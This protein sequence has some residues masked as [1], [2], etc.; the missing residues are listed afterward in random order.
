MTGTSPQRSAAPPFSDRGSWG[1]VVA[2]A[3]LPPG[4]EA[5][6]STLVTTSVDPARSMAP[7]TAPATRCM[8]RPL[9]RAGTA[10]GAA[11][12][13]ACCALLPP[14]PV[15]PTASASP[16]TRAGVGAARCVCADVWN[17]GNPA[18]SALRFDPASGHPVVSMPS[19]ALASSCAGAIILRV[20]S[21]SRMLSAASSASRALALRTAAT[22]TCWLAAV[23]FSPAA[24]LMVPNTRST[25][26]GAAVATA[27]AAVDCFTNRSTRACAPVAPRTAAKCTWPAASA[28]PHELQPSTTTVAPVSATL[29]SPSVGTTVS[30]PPCTMCTTAGC[31]PRCSSTST[32]ARLISAA[33][34]AHAARVG[35]P[36]GP[37]VI[38][39]I[40]RRTRL[41]VTS[42]RGSDAAATAL[43]SR[44][45][46]AV[47][48]ASCLAA[49]SS[50]QLGRCM[51]SS[52]PMTC[53]LAAG[54]PDSSSRWPPMPWPSMART[55]AMA[56]ACC[57]STS[58]TPTPYGLSLA[59]RLQA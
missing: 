12:L 31:P 40:S 42:M 44:C 25:S 51:S 6:P 5:A 54:P 28:M 29:N 26:T 49:A 58:T 37:S 19:S 11:T 7:F 20:S 59:A 9:P 14:A 39:S 18:I 4:P 10:C 43:T 27:T 46:L 17:A 3:A 21:D 2:S 33:N 56:S 35:L 13:G 34:S 23:P 22:A 36:N 53:S 45:S 55:A 16:A 47:A 15:A 57:S 8:G 50:R 52:A 41:S 48:P 30:P 1:K 32:S 24:V 38:S